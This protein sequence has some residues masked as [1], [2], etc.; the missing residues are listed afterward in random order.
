MNDSWPRVLILSDEGPQTGTAGGLLLHRLFRNCPPERVRV[1]ARHVPAIGEP[2]P[3]VAYRRLLPPWHRFEGSRFH[4]L[5]RSLRAWGLVPP[6][7]L[8]RLEALLDGFAPE[9]VC[10]VMQ[11][12]QY[13]DTAHRF[14]RLCGVPLVVL[15]HD[16][17]DEFEPVYSWAREAARRRDGAFYRFAA[18]RLGISPEMERLCAAWFGA[19]GAVLYPNR[20]EELSPRPFAMAD[21]LRQPGRLTIGFAGN[22]NYGYGRAISQ[23]LPALRSAGVRLVLYGRSP[24]TELVALAG[25]TDCCE[26][27]GFVA[28]AEAWAGI[29]RDCDAVLLPY[30]NPAGTMEHLYRHHFPSKLPEYLALGLP[31]I[32]TGPDYATGVRWARANS[33]AVAV[34]SGADAAEMTALF[35]KLATDQGARR[36]LAERGAEAGRRD[37]DPSAICSQFLAHLAAAVRR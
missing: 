25:A 23:M 21:T 34:A 28:S 22:L 5:K 35:Q 8:A 30:P 31:V 13:Y 17:N 1:I 6:A 32:V 3:G 20:S 9:V 19:D 2:L 4:R 27:R 14:A 7:P 24:G 15:V 33:A 10:C 37:F 29:Q 11:H 26:F 16:V 12:A 18:R 36:R